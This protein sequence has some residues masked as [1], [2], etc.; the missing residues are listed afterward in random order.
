MLNLFISDNH[1]EHVLTGSP[2]H[3]VQGPEG[4]GA[5]AGAGVGSGAGVGFCGDG[6]TLKKQQQ[7]SVKTHL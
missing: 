7:K 5:G 6:F 3:V 1:R 2:E 4:T